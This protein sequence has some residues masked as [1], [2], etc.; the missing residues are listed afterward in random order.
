MGPDIEA[1]VKKKS[2]KMERDRRRT[3]AALVVLA[4]AFSFT[5]IAAARGGAPTGDTGSRNGPV[6]VH[7]G[8][9]SAGRPWTPREMRAA[10]PFPMPSRRGPPVRENPDRS[11]PA[12]PGPPGNAPGSVGGPAR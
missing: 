1:A 2:M 12:Y 11:P 8:P 4:A 5:Q 6:V 9:G 3:I 10:K 7:S